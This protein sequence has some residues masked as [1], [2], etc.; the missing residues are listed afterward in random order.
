MIQGP[1]SRGFKAN[2]AIM[3]LY[4]ALTALRRAGVPLRSRELTQAFRTNH[5]PRPCP[6]L[7][8]RRCYAFST[9]MH[10]AAIATPS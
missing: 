10:R 3:A 8:W 4:P 6:V 7:S 5:A 2:I 9:V 1:G